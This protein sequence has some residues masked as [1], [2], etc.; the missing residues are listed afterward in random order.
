MTAA[1]SGAET[2]VVIVTPH[3]NLAATTGFIDP[4]RAA[5]YLEGRGRYQWRLVSAG[6]GLVE[7]SNGLTVMTDAV[8]D[9]TRRPDFAV[10]SSSWAPETHAAPGV[11]GALRRWERQGATVVGLDTGAFILARAGLLNGRK[12]TVHYE[13]FDAFEEMVPEAEP[14]LDL[15]VVD[16][17]CVTCCGG[18]AAV[19]LA[20]HLIARRHGPALSNAS[21]RYVF[22]Q[23]ARP[24][25]EPQNPSGSEPLGVAA[26]PALRHAVAIMEAHL[27]ETITIPEICVRIDLSQRQLERIFQ[28]FVRK[29]P[30]R[31]YS[32][33]RLDRAR[34]FVTQT[35]LPLGE[36]AIA[37][38]FSSQVHFSRAYRA[39]FG[40]APREDRVAGRVPFEY[41][42]WPLHRREADGGEG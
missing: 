4:F 32:D 6:G 42:A 17:P 18:A 14:S 23:S 41:R 29:S 37:C 28:Q 20:L 36:V 26:P 10:I 30:R 1:P 27:E 34:G 22:H 7:A 40:M 24:L 9:I 31:Y 38:G 5:N 11:T 19:D 15:F 39:R 21:A 35:T 33:I 13:H 12:A 16:G 2:L 8:A 25:G 3:F